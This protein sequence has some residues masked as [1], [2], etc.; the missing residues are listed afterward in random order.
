MSLF[1]EVFAFHLAVIGHSSAATWTLQCF[2]TSFVPHLNPP[3]FSVV[4][5]LKTTFFLLLF[6]MSL[7]LFTGLS[8]T[9]CYNY[10]F[11]SHF[12]QNN[13]LFLGFAPQKQNCT[14][15]MTTGPNIMLICSLLC[16]FPPPVLSSIISAS[17]SSLS[18]FLFFLAFYEKFPALHC[19]TLQ[20]FLQNCVSRKETPHRI[21]THRHSP[22]SLNHKYFWFNTKK[23]PEIQ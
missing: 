20:A 8:H 18:F 5:F 22:D 16:I 6:C 1:W 19:G 12:P 9:G 17:R 2:D 23:T 15:Q 11:L 13:Y 3:A 21:W 7:Q 10:S 4:P 14:L